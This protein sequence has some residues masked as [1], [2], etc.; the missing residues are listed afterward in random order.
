MKRFVT[1]L[2]LALPLGGL[3]FASDRTGQFDKVVIEIRVDADAL[4]DC[5]ETLEKLDTR[6]VFTD[7]GTW[8]PSLF[9]TDTVGETV[10]V[11]DA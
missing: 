5:R 8:L 2:A 4:S 7:T 10:C 1:L 3:A 9:S 6:E 11:V